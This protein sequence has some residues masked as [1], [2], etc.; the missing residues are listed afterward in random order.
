MFKD[1]LW[2]PGSYRRK[3]VAQLSAQFDLVMN[4]INF[5]FLKTFYDFFKIRLKWVELLAI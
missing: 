4:V 1:C 3:I 5:D 2:N